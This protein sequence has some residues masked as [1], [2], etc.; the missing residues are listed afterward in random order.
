MSKF[1]LIAFIAVLQP[2]GPESLE[3]LNF[4]L[5][6]QISSDNLKS[7]ELYVLETYL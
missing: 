5:L 2:P 7:I 4:V 6:F 3:N 1:K